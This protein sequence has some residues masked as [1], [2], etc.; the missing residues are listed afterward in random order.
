ML[1]DIEINENEDKAKMKVE[2]ER[3]IEKWVVE[4]PDRNVTNAENIIE[5]VDE[6]ERLINCVPVVA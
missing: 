6:Y 2:M 4:H 3:S 1:K 5:Y